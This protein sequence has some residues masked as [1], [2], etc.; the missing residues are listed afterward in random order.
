MYYVIPF[1]MAGTTSR[2]EAIGNLTEAA[3]EKWC[4]NTA[5]SV[6][7]IILP[8]PPLSGYR[9]NYC[10][11]KRIHRKTEMLS[12]HT[13]KTNPNN[14]TAQVTNELSVN[15][16]FYTLTLRNIPTIPPTATAL[17]ANQLWSTLALS[18]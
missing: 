10:R 11:W 12:G 17:D 18:S 15:Y 3:I 8:C 4:L 13:K 14:N 6:L 5:R 9:F 16:S 2:R 1:Y 7:D